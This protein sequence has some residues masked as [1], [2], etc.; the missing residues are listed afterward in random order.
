MFPT[1]AT[2]EGQAMMLAQLRT[3][4]ET[5]RSGSPA[6]DAGITNLF[7]SVIESWKQDPTTPRQLMSNLDRTL[8]NVWFSQDE[9]HRRVHRLLEE[10]RSTV[11]SLGGMTMN[12]RLVMFDLM[13]AWDQV[14]EEG[15]HA[16]Y[17]KLDA[18]P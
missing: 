13:D 4:L 10:F 18:S 9:T 12:E 3:E 5:L 2:F 16:L 7:L 17:A 15:R 6:S 14:T 11:E 8:G 1:A